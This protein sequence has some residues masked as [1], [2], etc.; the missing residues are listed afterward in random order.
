MAAGEE[1]GAR[2]LGPHLRVGALELA[3]DD[4]GLTPD[5]I[6][7]VNAHGTGTP[8]N[9]KM[10]ALGCLAVLGERMR[11]YDKGGE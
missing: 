11:R 9:D 4:A 10:E 7:T 3:L 2:R 6:D 1:E 8:E 5:R